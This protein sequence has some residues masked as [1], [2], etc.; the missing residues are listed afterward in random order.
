MQPRGAILRKIEVESSALKLVVVSPCGN[1]IAAKFYT[2]FG[3]WSAAMDAPLKTLQGHSHPVRS[4]VFS[5]DGKVVA[6]ASYVS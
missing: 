5:S 2:T 1:L 6:S 4:V 3:I